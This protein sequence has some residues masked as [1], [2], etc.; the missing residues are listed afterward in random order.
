[1]AKN[2]RM[3]KALVL[4]SGGLDSILAI[5]LLQT[6]GLRVEAINFVTPFSAGQSYVDRI[7]K[8]F[9]VKVHK[10]KVDREY[11]SLIRKP[12]HGYGANMNPCLDCKIYMF[13]RASLFAKKHGFDF[14]GTGEV[15]GERPFSQ[16][17]PLMFLIEK[18][19]GLEGKIVRPLSGMLLPTTEAEKKG[20][21][22]RENLLSISGRN[23][24]PQ[25]TLAKKLGVKEFPTPGG[26]C[27]LTDPYF[28][29]KLRDFLKHS[30]TFS[31][32][33]VALLRM[34][35]H[36]RIGREKIIVGR[37]HE[38]NLMLKKIAANKKLPWMEVL[39]YMGPVTIIQGKSKSLME[40]AAG[41]TVRYSDAP[42]NSAVKVA[43]H[44]R[45]KK[46]N[47][48]SKATPEE[49]IERIRV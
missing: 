32:D 33:D 20:L 18:E 37:R 21:I 45:K 2:P 19:A 26:G 30:R 14:I 47:L 4:F 22:S 43:L 3:P 7:A 1:M 34:G 49:K 5:R 8:K 24:T 42:K 40:K 13:R 41:L 6:Q 35:R 10:V 15:L 28:A 23:R 12:R 17:K 27:L 31:W 16:V 25:L 44:K 36:F 38:E 48:E 46:T 39:D 9:G 29:H 11:F